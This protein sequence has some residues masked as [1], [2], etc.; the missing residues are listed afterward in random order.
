MVTALTEL[1]YLMCSRMHA[2]KQFNQKLRKLLSAAVIYYACI[3][4]LIEVLP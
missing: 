4:P 3:E 1:F 2:L